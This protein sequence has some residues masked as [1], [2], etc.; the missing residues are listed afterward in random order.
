MW[1]YLFFICINIFVSLIGY[2]QSSTCANATPFC[3]GVN[4]TFPA[5]TNAPAPTGAYFDCLMTQPN[6][7][8]FYLEIANPGNI[9]I[10]IRGLE[11]L[12]ETRILISSAGDH[13]QIQQ[14]CVIN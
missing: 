5:S 4:Y 10:N 6:P 2:A 12:G 7:A 3:T 11:V 14:L 9:T 13:L 1:K 8:F